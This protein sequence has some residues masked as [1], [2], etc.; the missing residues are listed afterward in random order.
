[1]EI[2]DKRE[3]AVGIAFRIT[4][5]RWIVTELD[6]LF[7]RCVRDAVEGKNEPC[8]SYESVRK[9]RAP[10]VAL[11]DLKLSKRFGLRIKG[12]PGFEGP[13]GYLSG[14]VAEMASI[15]K[16]FD[17]SVTGCPSL[18]LIGEQLCISMVVLDKRSG[19][20][21]DQFTEPIDPIAVIGG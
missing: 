13:V 15:L 14:T 9:F 17:M 11:I 8:Y 19:L 6:G 20:M 18:Y 1:M 7:T 10:F 12:L 5:T 4:E 3:N 16:S 21:Y 2:T